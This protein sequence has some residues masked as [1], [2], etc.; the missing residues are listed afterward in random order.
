MLG[1]GSGT[2][3]R[4]SFVGLGVVLLREEYHCGDGL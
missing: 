3:R 2:I 4:Y 1:P